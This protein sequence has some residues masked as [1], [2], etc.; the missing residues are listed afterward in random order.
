[1]V[2]ANLQASVPN[3]EVPLDNWV[4]CEKL[5]CQ[6]TMTTKLSGQKRGSAK[7]LTIINVPEERVLQPMERLATIA[8]IHDIA[9]SVLR[10]HD[11][12]WRGK[13][14]RRSL[15]TRIIKFKR[16]IAYL[17]DGASS[18]RRRADCVRTKGNK[19]W[20]LDYGDDDKRCEIQDVAILF[21]ASLVYFALLQ[22]TR[23]RKAHVKFSM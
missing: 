16:P 7:K 13:T 5:L 10:P 14:S 12:Y 1:M 3:L 9:S 18:E 11:L 2:N 21:V 6:K 19:C 15:W 22:K 8:M 4:L 20:L 23:R 17:K